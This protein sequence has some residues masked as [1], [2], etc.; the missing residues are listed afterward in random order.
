MRNGLCGAGINAANPLT[1]L[2]LMP[3]LYLLLMVYKL[4]TES[5]N[6]SV[7]CK[8]KKKMKKKNMH[9]KSTIN[10]IKKIDAVNQ[11][12]LHSHC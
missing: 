12:L 3:P 10:N 4:L 11:Q 8:P 9:C 6:Q 2:P 5:I 7:S 1:L